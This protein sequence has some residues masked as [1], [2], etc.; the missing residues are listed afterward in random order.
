[1]AQR[2]S[3]ADAPG[4]RKK[5]RKKYKR[6]FP[7]GFVTTG[8]LRERPPRTGLCA[9]IQDSG[10]IHG[11]LFL[12]PVDTAGEPVSSCD[13]V[14]DIHAG[15]E[16]AGIRHPC[17]GRPNFNET[18]SITPPDDDR[19]TSRSGRPNWPA[20]VFRAG[21]FIRCELVSL[22]AICLALH[23]FLTSTNTNFTVQATPLR[24]QR[25]SSPSSFPQKRYSLVPVSAINESVFL[26]FNPPAIPNL[27]VNTFQIVSFNFTV[28]TRK[29]HIGVIISSKHGDNNNKY[30]N[31][32]TYTTVRDS[33]SKTVQ[34][35]P[36]DQPYVIASTSIINNT[37]K[38][39]KS[40]RAE[41]SSS[42]NSTPSTR[43][44]SWSLTNS[45]P[46]SN[47]PAGVSR[48]TGKKD[49][50][51]SAYWVMIYSDDDSIA[52]PL[53]TSSNRLAGVY[54]DAKGS[55]V[56][57]AVWPGRQ[58]NFSVEARHIGRVT[59]SVA[60]V[61]IDGDRRISQVR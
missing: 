44:T 9:T 22:L 23:G 37:T 12:K 34:S 43:S 60:V 17:S 56:L 29:T 45:T 7:W 13:Y 4:G 41:L 19:P 47:T 46:K 54:A 25:Y 11:L 52:R 20:Q 33:T 5:R 26:F 59:M 55:Y 57:M 8:R 53:I 38:S 58:H 48:T 51:G 18:H 10:I 39:P 15:C 32:K 50:R 1:M 2:T 42:I 6:A 16:S 21:I 28:Y 24:P 35:V 31:T 61:D 3:C 49:T 14:C 30:N 27:R 36:L 40:S